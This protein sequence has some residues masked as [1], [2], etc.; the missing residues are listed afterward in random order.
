VAEQVRQL[1]TQSYRVGLEYADE[2]RYKTSSWQTGTSF[3]GSREADVMANL[4][5]FLNEHS[6]DYVRLIGIDPKSKR[7][8]VETVI[9]KP[10]KR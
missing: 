5:A 2:R 9:H 1:L 8:V 6:S 3:Q 4:N 7:R 10:T